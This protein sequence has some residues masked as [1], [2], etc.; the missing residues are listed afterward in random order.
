[1]RTVLHAVTSRRRARQVDSARGSHDSAK[2]SAATFHPGQVMGGAPLQGGFPKPRPGKIR[3]F[4]SHIGNQNQDSS[5]G[6]IE[7]EAA[8]ENYIERLHCLSFVHSDYSFTYD[9][10]GSQGFEKIEKAAQ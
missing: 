7:G 10:V 1:M 6:L 8:M 9:K 4:V 3:M 2:L 5:A